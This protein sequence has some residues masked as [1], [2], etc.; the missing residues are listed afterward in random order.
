MRRKHALCV[1]SGR[2]T[3]RIGKGGGLGLAGPEL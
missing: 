3:P 2:K 1:L